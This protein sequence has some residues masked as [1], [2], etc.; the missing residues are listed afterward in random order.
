VQQDL[1]RGIKA[2]M[3]IQRHFDGRVQALDKL[4]KGQQ[5]RIEHLG[6]K[7]VAIGPT[8][9]VDGNSFTVTGAVDAPSSSI[10]RTSSGETRMFE[11][12]FLRED[13]LQK[14]SDPKLR[15]M[16]TDLW[17]KSTSDQYAKT[18]VMAGYIAR[19]KAEYEAAVLDRRPFKVDT[20]LLKGGLRAILDQSLSTNE[21]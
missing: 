5:E 8:V 4:L 1:A 16:A 12:K 15:L 10:W 9:K 11:H 2:Q 18:M 13:T 20:S 6:E 7:W 17:P 19:N 3:V 14:G 21:I